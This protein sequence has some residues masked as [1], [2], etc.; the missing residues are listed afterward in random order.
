MFSTFVDFKLSYYML[1]VEFEGFKAHQYCDNATCSSYGLVGT[2]N[3]TTHS[4]GQG[5]V[6]CKQCKGKPFSVR[7]GTLFFDCR[8]P[9][10]KM[11][12]CL[13]SL[14]S[15]TGQN[16]VCRNEKVDGQSLRRWMLL[17]SAQVSAFSAHLQEGMNLSEVQ[18]DEFWSYIKKKTTT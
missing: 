2:G 9:V 8:T 17:A 6:R 18:I 1:K 15:G 4:V 14:A 13:Q 11:A 3:L 16:A 5:Q 10:E 7:K 12:R